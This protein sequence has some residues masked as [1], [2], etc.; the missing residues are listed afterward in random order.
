[1]C[2]SHIGEVDT[3]R[4]KGVCL[5]FAFEVAVS[6]FAF[7]S[8]LGIRFPWAA[9]GAPRP[10][11]EKGGFRFSKTRNYM[12]PS[13]ELLAV[14]QSAGMARKRYPH[15]TIPMAAIR[16][17]PGVWRVVQYETSEVKVIQ[18]RCGGCLRGAQCTL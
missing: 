5:G 6:L 7:C 3:S 13:R 9:I 11:L 10:L 16:S 2:Q 17:S 15:P 4:V 1:M 12:D 14:S 8:S 18:L